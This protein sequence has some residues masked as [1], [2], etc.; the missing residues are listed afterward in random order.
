MA[1]DLKAVEQRGY[2]KG[3]Q[4]G[5][6]RKRREIRAETLD[7]ER[8]AFRDRVFVKRY[9]MTMTEHEARQLCDELGELLGGA[10][11]SVKVPRVLEVYK[12][13]DKELRQC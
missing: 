8:Q 1:D 9:T 10:G 11:D 12:L 7:R 13:L 2:S 5:Q 3:Y 6:R 4:A